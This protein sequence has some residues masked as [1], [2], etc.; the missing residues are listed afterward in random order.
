[1]DSRLFGSAWKPHLFYRQYILFMGI[2]KNCRRMAIYY[3]QFFD[4]DRFNRQRAYQIH[5]T[6]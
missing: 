3:R 5:R 4:V 2:F 6:L 1:M